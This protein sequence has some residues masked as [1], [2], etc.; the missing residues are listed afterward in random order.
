MNHSRGTNLLMTPKM[1]NVRQYV[2]VK[3]G[4]LTMRFYHIYLMGFCSIFYGMYM[5]SVYKILGEDNGIDD[6][7]LTIAGSCG[8]VAN[9]AS[10][11][12]S[13]LLV[14]RYGF[15][16]IYVITL[17]IQILVASTIYFVVKLDK[18]VYFIWIL[19]SQITLASHFSLF[20]TVV[21]KIYGL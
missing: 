5:I 16:K 3:E 8:A 9:A 21:G 12:G 1:H 18:Y 20:P 19:L 14:D 15:K 7:T 6:L 17:L 11:F 4:L 13:G 2:T 10:K